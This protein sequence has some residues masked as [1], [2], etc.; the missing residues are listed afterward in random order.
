MENEILTLKSK[1]RLNC[2]ICDRCC[3]YRGDIRLTPINVLEISKFLKIDLKDFIDTYTQP[4]EGEPPEIV[5]KAVGEDRVCIFNDDKTYKCKIH[6]FRPIQCVMFPLYPVDVKNDL[7]IN[8]G[9]CIVE[10]N[11]KT[12]VNKWLNGDN[13]YKRNKDIYLKW[14]D[15]IEEIQPKWNTF[16]KE[17]QVKIREILFL[18]YDL[19]KSF[20]KQ[21]LENIKKV[22]EIVYK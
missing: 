13:I 5:I 21:I 2:S 12:R 10:T 7:F 3:K 19:K 4:L 11:K 6:K 15:F 9:T 1:T 14:I 18:E 20:K 16:S 8:Q 17:K 22:R